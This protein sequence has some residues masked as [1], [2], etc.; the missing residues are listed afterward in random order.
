[1]LD[2]DD[3]QRKETGTVRTY[4]VTIPSGSEGLPLTAKVDAETEDEARQKVI[5]WVNQRAGYHYCDSLPP[6]TKV[7]VA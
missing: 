7:K 5:D 3:E 2:P 6:G 1:M 4:E